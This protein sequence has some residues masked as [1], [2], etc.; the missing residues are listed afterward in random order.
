MAE[1]GEAARRAA[2]ANGMAEA[3]EVRA[4]E[5]TEGNAGAEAAAEA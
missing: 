3:A 4:A 5:T 2:T 1:A